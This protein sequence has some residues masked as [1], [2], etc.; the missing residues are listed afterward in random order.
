MLSSTYIEAPSAPS[1]QTSGL[2]A[3]EFHTVSGKHYQKQE[4]GL[5]IPSVPPAL[6][7]ARQLTA[8]P[9]SPSLQKNP[10]GIAKVLLEGALEYGN[11]LRS[12]RHVHVLG[13]HS[14]ILFDRDQLALPEDKGKPGIVRLFYAEKGLH[15]LNQFL[16]TPGE[17]PT[18]KDYRC[19]PHNHDSDIAIIPVVNNT[20]HLLFENDK[21]ANS[22]ADSAM[23]LHEHEFVQSAMQTGAYGLKWLG[24]RA[25]EVT[26]YDMLV[27]S[28]VIQLEANQK[29]SITGFEVEANDTTA[30]IVVEGAEIPKVNPLIYSTRPNPSLDPS[31]LYVDASSVEV[32]NYLM[33]AIEKMEWEG[34]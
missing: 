14:I 30:W 17:D 1:P 15:E 2:M 31:R 10:Q 33:D 12:K 7:L 16:I 28:D 27:P 23:T 9:L 19:M 21:K 25:M 32:E 24:A 3:S 13:L 18:K 26:S 8:D 6:A 5:L 29:H 20:A 22:V 4:S 11:T 34:L